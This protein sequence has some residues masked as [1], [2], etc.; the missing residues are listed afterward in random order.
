MARGT[1]LA[2]VAEQLSASTSSRWNVLNV[3]IGGGVVGREIVANN[4][5]APHTVEF[6]W[7]RK[8]IVWVLAGT[9]NIGYDHGRLH[10]DKLLDATETF[11]RGLQAAGYEKDQCFFTDILR[12]DAGPEFEE[13]RLAFNSEIG[14]RLADL[15]HVIPS[16]SNPALQNPFD[17]TLFR[18]GVHPT[19]AGDKYLAADAIAA[20]RPVL[21]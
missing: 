13:D 3:A 18:D 15:A 8:N 16:G 17:K 20:M 9:N 21:R 1:E 2:Q 5:P 19:P 14:N 7:R 11:F 4:V 10:V 12:R 6:P